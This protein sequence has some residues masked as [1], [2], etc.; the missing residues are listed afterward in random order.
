LTFG[1]YVVRNQDGL[2]DQIVSARWQFIEAVSQVVPAFLQLLREQ[3][4][5]EY[6]RLADGNPDYWVMGWKFETWQLLSDR[7][8]QLTPNLMSWA[9]KFNVQGEDWIL[10]GAL[11]TL[12]N[13]HG[14]PEQRAALEIWG[15]RQW[16]AVDGVVSVEEQRF[17]FS[18]GGWDPTQLSSAAWRTAVRERFE[19]AVEAHVRRIRKLIADRGALPVPSR[20][21]P[22]HFQWLA[23]YQCGNLSLDA[24]LQRS[25]HVTDKTTI[26][27]G[28]S[29]AARLAAIAVRPKRGKLKKP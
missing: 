25:P 20:F 3:V 6:V 10:A 11:Q 13:W 9:R 15:F 21:S 24:I 19:E 8:N 14:F 29:N 2:D 18:D 4:Y 27:K 7:E 22:D 1:D 23:L 12:S 28:I 26:S 17:D 5:P 16:I